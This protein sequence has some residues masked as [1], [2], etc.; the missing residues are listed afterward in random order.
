CWANLAGCILLEIAAPAYMTYESRAQDAAARLRL[1]QALVWMRGQVADG[2]TRDTRA[3]LAASPQLPR[4]GSRS[5][6]VDE[7]GTGLR[8]ALF[9]PQRDTHWAI[10]LPPQLHVPAATATSGH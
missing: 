10:P 1:L 6:E 4:G 3:L 8:M 5:I 9:N 7:D 2:D